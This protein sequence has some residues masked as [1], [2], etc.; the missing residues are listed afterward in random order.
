MVE[1]MIVVLIIGMLASMVTANVTRAR[2]DARRNVCIDNIRQIDSAKSQ[3][4]IEHYAPDQTIPTPEDLDPYI[5]GGTA[6]IYCP[7]D[8]TKSFAN[9]YNVNELGIIPTCRLA[10]TTHVAPQS[11]SGS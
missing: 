10:P 8:S 5:R 3:W 2:S 1:I 7:I 11:D 6:K 4:S 9:S